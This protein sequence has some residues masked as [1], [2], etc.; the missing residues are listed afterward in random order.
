MLAERLQL[1]SEHFTFFLYQNVC[2]RA[3]MDLW[4]DVCVE[5]HG[6]VWLWAGVGVGT[7][8]LARVCVRSRVC[9]HARAR[10]CVLVWC[11]C[12]LLS[13]HAPFLLDNANLRS[14]FEKDKLLFALLI[15]TTVKIDAGAIDPCGCNT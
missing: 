14:L 6:C 4:G 3:E 13:H 15:S 7:S 8:V 12:G 2:R 5:L 9:V 11:S 1:L 10:A